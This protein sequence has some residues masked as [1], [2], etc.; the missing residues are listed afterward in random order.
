MYVYTELCNTPMAAATCFWT[1]FKMFTRKS[2]HFFCFVLYVIINICNSLLTLTVQVFHNHKNITQ[3]LNTTITHN[4]VTLQFTT[5]CMFCSQTTGMGILLL[6][7]HV[8]QDF[9]YA[10]DWL[11]S[12]IGFDNRGHSS[13]SLVLPVTVIYWL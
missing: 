6:I 9:P 1:F 4:H 8:W 12:V 10:A 13:E 5:D 2:V 7:Y 11:G 3:L